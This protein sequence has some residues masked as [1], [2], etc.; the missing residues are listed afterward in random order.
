MRRTVVSVP[1]KLILM[2][3]HAAVYGRPAVVAAIDLRMR[4]EIAPT[5]R[6]GVQIELPDVGF[7]GHCGWEEI[8]VYTGAMRRRWRSYDEDP[9]PERFRRLR[10]HDPTALVK[11][12]LGEAAAE[13]GPR[14]HLPLR[15]RIESELPVGVGFGSSSATAVGVITALMCCVDDTTDVERIER[16]ALQVER[17]QHGHPSGVDG[18]TV[19]RGGVV[20][21]VADGHGTPAVQQLP[22]TES[23]LGGL[24]VFNTGK[25]STSTGE[26]VAEVHARQRRD[27]VAFDAIL[28]RL[29]T[30]TRSLR[31]QLSEDD[32][33]QLVDTIRSSEAAL[34]ALQVVPLPV[35]RLIR[36]IERRGGAAKISGAGSLG[37][38][39]AGSLLVYHPYAP[40]VASWDVLE[41]L[42]H[43]TARLGAAGIRRESAR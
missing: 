36:E 18:A 14:A 15:L 27:P 20:W 37:G 30:A 3:E 7:Q 39:G 4:V 8:T 42:P 22:V 17:C 25:P 33:A 31:V 40:D 12:A 13:L 5:E 6:A 34:E 1:G 16:L 21:A 26:V 32:G 23:L 28:D 10:D 11:V 2:G 41:Q 35:Q 24:R 43:Y 19:L 9:G 38:G 29:E